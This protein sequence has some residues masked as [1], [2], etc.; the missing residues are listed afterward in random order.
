MDMNDDI[1]TD[2]KTLFFKAECLVHYSYVST[3][4]K[5]MILD[6][7][8]SDYTLYDPEIST[9][10][11]VDGDT[12]E[13]YFCCGNCSSIGIESFIKSHKCNEY[14]KLMCLPRCL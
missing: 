7:Q 14:C 3:N 6:I 9:T 1:S 13:L 4:E 11:L 5:M 10:Q 12:E 2:L 8:G